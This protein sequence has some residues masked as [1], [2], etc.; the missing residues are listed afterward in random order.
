MDTKTQIRAIRTL[1]FVMF[2]VSLW[3]LAAVYYFMNWEPPVYYYRKIE[4]M[5]LSNK[6]AFVLECLTVL[7]TMFVIYITTKLLKFPSVCK[8]IAAQPARR[9]QEVEVLRF[10]FLESSCLLNGTLYL[11]CQM[12]PNFYLYVISL[13]A[14]VFLYPNRAQCEEFLGGEQENEED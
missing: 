8:Y 13:I 14:F 12:V 9:F 5:T 10:A 2:F 3:L 7:Y 4:P 1:Y 6:T 11:L